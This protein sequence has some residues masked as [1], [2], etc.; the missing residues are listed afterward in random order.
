MLSKRSQI[1][2]V[3]TLLLSLSL[4]CSLTGG[5][6]EKT[7]SDQ[8]SIEAA[9]AETLAAEGAEASVPDAE[10]ETETQPEPDLIFQGISFAFDP[11]LAESVNAENIPAEGDDDNLWF[12][13]P[14]HIKFTFNNWILPEAFHEAAIRV[15]P[16]EDFQ[17]VNTVM[18]DIFDGLQSAF[19]TNPADNEGIEVADL[20][21][22]AQFFISQVEYL[23]FQNGSGVRFLSQYGQA[24]YPVGWPH[25]FYTFQ[26]ITD[27]KAYY[28]SV[29]L[30]VN[31]PSLPHPDNVVLDDAFY[32]NFT[33]YVAD[34]QTQLNGKD[35]GTFNPSLLL[36]DA[37]VESLLVE[38]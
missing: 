15:Y 17:A 12:S 8:D 2:L 9:V 18:T 35:P 30:P 21:G 19:E 6:A 1:L 22:A 14:D 3:I 20:F 24:G 7:G 28:I 23:E 31:H 5:S 38:P 32:D 37:V 34:M 4:A 27:D 13:T 36:M 16:V 29:I 11:S 26:G 33:N 25:M 10:P